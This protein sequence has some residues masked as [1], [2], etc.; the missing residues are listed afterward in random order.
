[1]CTCK[2][3]PHSYP[4]VVSLSS[5][6]KKWCFITSN[7]VITWIDAPWE[8]RD[9]QKHLILIHLEFEIKRSSWRWRCKRCNCNVPGSIQLGSRLFLW[10]PAGVKC[11]GLKE[12]RLITIKN[13]RIPKNERCL[14]LSPYFL[15][16]STVNFQLKGKYPKFIFEEGEAADSSHPTRMMSLNPVASCLSNLL[17]LR[18]SF[19][20][21]VR[22][23]C[24]HLCLSLFPTG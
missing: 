3:E 9:L 2:P 4:C 24:H 18:G 13:T 10:P 21:V 23:F 19:P 1:M 11:L 17:S 14:V 6:F 5:S 20:S 7:C 12:L 8:K 16:I 22:F 15:F